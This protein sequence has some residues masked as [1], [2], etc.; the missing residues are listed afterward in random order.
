MAWKLDREFPTDLWAEH[1][2]ASDFDVESAA[3]AYLPLLDARF[4]ASRDIGLVEAYCRNFLPS[5]KIFIYGAGTHTRALLPVLRRQVGIEILGIVDRL[6]ASVGEFEG[7]PVILPEALSGRAFDYVLLSHTQ[8]ET[9]AAERLLTLGIP[10]DKIVPIYTDDRFRGFSSAALMK[11]IEAFGARKVENVLINC[12]LD[13]IVGDAELQSLL[14]PNKTVRL[15]MGRPDSWQPCGPYEAIDLHESLDALCAV[16]WT[17]KP[18]TVYVRSIIYKN[19]LSMVIKK[20]FPDIFVVHEVYDYAISWRDEDLISL[21]G[22]GV[23]TI[24]EIRMTELYSGNHVDAMISKRGGRYWNSVA[25]RCNSP[26]EL[27]SPLIAGEAATVPARPDGPTRLVYCGFLPAA[28]FLAQ[29]KN[30]Y[31]FLNLMEA[32]GQRGGIEVDLFNAVHFDE[33]QD[34]IFQNYLGRFATGPVH[35]NRRLPFSDLVARM[36][37]YDLGWLCE[38]V[39]FF[40][41]DRYF[42]IGNRWT[43]N[44]MAGL[45]TMIDDSWKLMG[46]LTTEY[47]AG[48]VVSDVS[49]DGIVAALD[50]ARPKDMRSGVRRLHRHLKGRNEAALDRIAGLSDRHHRA[51]GC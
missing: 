14:P 50:Q 38:L 13:G 18:K 15:F 29:F 34:S 30:G 51:R 36:R 19:F 31:N 37:D 2:F 6:A 32:L 21:F 5:G 33:Q 16:L 22:L 12:T 8:Y 26:Y 41:P 42:G 1:G 17:L 24:S 20:R 45:P 23:K 44:I 47:D 7:A 46:D 25:D 35:Y 10:G 4:G 11:R 3:T 27:Y 49:V 40:Q 39:D 43:S 48:I 9:E 28:S